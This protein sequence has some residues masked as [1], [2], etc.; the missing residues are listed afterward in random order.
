MTG[1]Q[2]PEAPAGHPQRWL[3]LWD[4]SKVA[5]P[6]RCY[7]SRQEGTRKKWKG[8]LAPR[9]QADVG[10]WRPAEPDGQANESAP[11]PPPSFSDSP[12][13]ATPAS[14][15]CPARI[16]IWACRADGDCQSLTWAFTL[17]CTALFF[18][19]HLFFEH[20]ALSVRIPDF[21]RAQ[22]TDTG[23]TKGTQHHSLAFYFTSPS[24]WDDTLGFTLLLARYPILTTTLPLLPHEP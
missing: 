13:G 11:T 4:A 20:F 24:L 7:L 6:L 1:P 16:P 2:S 8:T 14:H 17:H 23:Y 10:R 3:P 9:T 12:H 15:N 19:L 18:F 22:G 21:G 5:R